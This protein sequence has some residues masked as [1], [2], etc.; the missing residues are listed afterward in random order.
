[1][2]NIIETFNLTKVYNEKI[3]AVD[4]LNLAIKKGEIF[5]LLGPNGAG[6]TTTI[7]MLVTLTRPTS[8]RAVIDGHDLAK[9]ART[10]R[11]IIG[12]SSQQAGVD[13]NATGREYLGLFGN[14]YHL[15]GQTIKRRI[16]EVLELMELEDAADRLISTY[17]GGMQ[18]RLEIATALIN[19]PKILILDEPTLGLDVQ[20]RLRIWDY[21]RV[22]NK[23]DTTI[24]MTTHYLEE[25]DKLC[26]RVAIVDHGKIVALGT[27][28]ELKGEISGDAVT[29]T[30]PLQDPDQH[31]KTMERAT[32]L[33]SSQT[34]VR[35]VVARDDGLNVYVDEGSSAVPQILRVLEEAD[36]KAEGISLTRPSLDDVFVKYTGRTLREEKGTGRGALGGVRPRGGR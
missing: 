14:Y 27:P 4:D 9:E 31:A 1:L 25:T 22:I 33:L 24:L 12:Y 17:S 11:Q 6:K 29:L 23:E 21:I 30:L 16:K 5:G 13:D 10:I 32:Q 34:Y 15:D 28:D 26:D 20:T 3:R 8:G 36:V 2:T 19:K 35:D 18:K 7:R